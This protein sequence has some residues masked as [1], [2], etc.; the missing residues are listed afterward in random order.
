MTSQPP[1]TTPTSPT[2]AEAP[3]GQGEALTDEQ[4]RA[5]MAGRPLSPYCFQQGARFAEQ[6]HGIVTPLP[7]QVQPAEQV[8]EPER[9]DSIILKTLG[10]WRIGPAYDYEDVCAAVQ[11]ALAS[12]AQQQPM[13]ADTAR[14]ALDLLNK[15]QDAL[16]RFVAN[17]RNP[18]ADATVSE[19]LG[20]HDT[21]HALKVRR[22]LAALTPP[23]APGG[24][25]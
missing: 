5:G 24:A 1:K 9:V 17:H 12:S 13:S 3:A 6:H 8:G 11:A 19:L 2:P 16:A 25:A 21:E 23:Q 20:L 7:A 4:I 10:T 14:D 18:N 22:A 15:T